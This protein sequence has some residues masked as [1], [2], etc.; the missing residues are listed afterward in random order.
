MISLAGMS[1][2][3]VST[4]RSHTVTGRLELSQEKEKSISVEKELRT[5]SRSLKGVN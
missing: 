1:V 3:I 5:S 4:S 2:T